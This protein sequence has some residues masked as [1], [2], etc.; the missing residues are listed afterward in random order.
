[1]KSPLAQPPLYKI[2]QGKQH[3][4]LKDD[5]GLNQYLTQGALDGASLLLRP[6]LYKGKSSH[7]SRANLEILGQ[8]LQ[9]RAS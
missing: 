5:E 3:Q 8:A 6:Y 7:S 9:K 4:Y 1:M 2:A